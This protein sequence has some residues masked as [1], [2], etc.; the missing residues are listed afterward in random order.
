MNNG[1]YAPEICNEFAS[2]LL[3]KYLNDVHLDTFLFIGDTEEKMKNAL[4]RVVTADKRAEEV[5]AKLQSSLH[6]ADVKLAR[7]EMGRAGPSADMDV[8]RT[9]ALTSFGVGPEGDDLTAID[10][11]EVVDTPFGSIGENPAPGD[12]VIDEANEAIASQR[13]SSAG[14]ASLVLLT[15]LCH[16]ERC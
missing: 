9:Q 12:S 4:A 13:V 14:L 15:N 7:Q 5:Q 6:L 16:C 10:K 1:E 8:A 11:A 3:G 2:E